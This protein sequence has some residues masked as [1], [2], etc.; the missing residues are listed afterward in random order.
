[1]STIILLILL[2]A[3]IILNLILLP[4]HLNKPNK[5]IPHIAITTQR[6]LRGSPRKYK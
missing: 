1:M 5:G 2:I 4:K 3:S 6:S